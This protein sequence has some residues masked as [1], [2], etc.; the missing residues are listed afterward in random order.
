V[1]LPRCDPL[2]YPRRG[3]RNATVALHA[4]S[5]WGGSEVAMWDVSP[6]HSWITITPGPWPDGGVATDPWA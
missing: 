4:T 6:H 5:A 3:R 2:S 1:D